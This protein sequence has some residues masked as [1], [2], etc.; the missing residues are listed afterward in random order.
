[1]VAIQFFEHP[2]SIII[3]PE[4]ALLGRSYEL[5]NTYSLY[6]LEVQLPDDG[7]ASPYLTLAATL[8]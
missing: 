8:S 4:P 5:C 7:L 6:Q 1:M 3:C 2:E